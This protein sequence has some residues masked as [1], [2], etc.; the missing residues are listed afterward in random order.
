MQ[1]RTLSRMA[2]GNAVKMGF[3]MFFIRVR[4]AKI[5]KISLLPNRSCNHESDD[6]TNSHNQ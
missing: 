5:I 6:S 4:V 1:R 2:Y 3:K